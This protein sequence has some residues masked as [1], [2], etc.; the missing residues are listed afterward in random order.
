MIGVGVDGGAVGEANRAGRSI[1]LYGHD[2]SGRDDLCAELGGLPAGPFGQLCTGD[3]VGK[4]EIVLD[5]EL[6]GLPPRRRP[7]DQNTVRSPSDAP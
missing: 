2:F 6:A 7:L 1:D 4:A 5:A 3:T